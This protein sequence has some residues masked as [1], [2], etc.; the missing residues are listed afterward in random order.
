MD[1]FDEL[2]ARLTHVLRARWARRANEA[3]EGLPRGATVVLAGHRAAGKSRLLPHVAQR[4]GRVGVDLD[5][6]LSR[7]RPLHE[8]VKN[9]VASFRAAERQA[10]REVPR[11][12]VVSV[13]GGFL[14][15]HGPVLAGCVVVLVPV[16][17]ETY[18]ER[19]IADPTRPRLRPELS[20]QAELRE[21]FTER[22]DLHRAA[23]PLDF[24]DFVLKLDRGLRARR[25][26]TAPP[27]VDVVEFAW[28][29]RHRGADLLELRTDLTPLKTE[30]LP[31]RRALP[32]LVAERG[33]PL[34]DAWR[35][36]AELVDTELGPS[37]SAVGPAVMRSLHAPRALSTRDALAAWAN[38]D[39]GALVKHVEP[40]ESPERAEQL[41]QTQA[42]LIEHFGAERVTVLAT[43]PLALPTRARL[44]ERNALDY[45][46]A[47]PGWSAAPGQR[48]VADATR[49]ARRSRPAARAK[50]RLGIIGGFVAHSRSPR[51]HEQPF[52]RIE[53][54]VD[55]D[56]GPLL[57]SL[58][59][60]H[61]G[62]AVTN[63]FKKRVAQI[64][65]ASEAAVNT[66]VRTVDGWAASNTDH[67]GALAMLEALKAPRVTVLGNGG[68]TEAIRVAAQ[69]FRVELTLRSR[70]DAFA[71]PLSGAVVWTWPADVEPPEALRFAG[72][73]VAVIA[74][75]V[76]GR[77]VAE[78]IRAKGGMPRMLG[79]RWFMAQA[80]LQKSLWEN[81]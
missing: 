3:S 5:E 49:E 15:A 68:A 19:L 72:A 2:D 14:A 71:A 56:L 62:L 20:L 21:V 57:R 79:P 47:D 42:A 24:V 6:V 17:Y 74:Y 36:A 48:L 33:T 32:I 22:E 7:Q 70:Q 73:Q 63:P 31:V 28:H 52:D 81:A 23:H 27:G 54:P 12:A 64:V 35:H 76:P 80:R 65:G 39:R 43:G 29:S 37:P 69:Q 60:S 8:W 75:G 25:V 41:L 50:G 40:L 58:H 55:T 10:F 1:L 46:A 45:T 11:G 53:L 16:T 61:R 44:A 13:G 77:T 78:R 51:I 67:A 66:L 34:P 59:A 9:D 30:L 4:L 26:V 38:V 18:V